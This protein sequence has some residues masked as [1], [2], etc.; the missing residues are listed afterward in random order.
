[1]L[2]IYFQERFIIVF[3][4]FGIL[5]ISYIN[6]LSA[7]KVVSFNKSNAQKITQTR[8]D[9]KLLPEQKLSTAKSSR[10]VNQYSFKG[11]YLFDSKYG[12]RDF[13]V[14]SIP[15][16]S[17]VSDPGEPALPVNIDKILVPG[18]AKVNI[19]IVESQSVLLKD[20]YIQP[21]LT[22]A[23][24]T[25]GDDDRKFVIDSRVYNSNSFYPAK[26]VYQKSGQLLR[27]NKIVSIAIAPVQFNPVKK[28]LRVYTKIKYK[29]TY[30]SRKTFQDLRKENS[31][32]YL[33]MMRNI[34]LNA[35]QIPENPK[36]TST[37]SKASAN[38]DYIILTHDNYHA[39]ADK[40][41]K[42]KK[43][44]GYSTEVLSS[45][46]WTATKVKD[47][48][49][50]RYANYSPKPDYFVIIGDQ[51][52][53]PAEIHQAPDGTNFGTDLYY[54][55]MDGSTD[56]VPD[57]AHGRISVSSSTEALN[58][59][60]KIVNY[61]R[62]PV[63]DSSFYNKG[64]NCAYFQGYNYNGQTYCERRFLHTSE[65]IRSYLMNQGYNIERIYETDATL[66]P[67][68]YQNGYYS[69]GQAIPSG[70][71][72]SNGFQWDGSTQ[73]ITSSINNGR[74]F[75]FHRDH[76]YTNG[77]GWAHPKF[78][79]HPNDQHVQNLSNGNKLPVVFSIDCHTGDFTQTEAFAE[80]FL[81]HSNGGAVGVVAP[82]YYSYSGPNDGFAAGL[83]DAVW[84]SPGLIPDFGAGGISNPS[85]S[86]HGDIRTM[87]NVVNQALI[88]MEETWNGYGSRI[89]YS[90]EVYHYF[91]DP[92]M[93]IFTAKPSAITA[94]INDTVKDFSIE[95]KNASDNDALATAYYNGKLL[96]KTN[97]SNGSGT[98]NYQDSIEGMVTVT[99]SGVNKKPLV[100]KLYVD[101]VVKSYP[102]GKQA[103]NISVDSSSSKSVSL[104]ITWDEGTGDHRIA[105]INNQDNFTDPVDGQEYT[106]DN[107][108][109]HN[110][111]QVVY[112]GEGN[113]VTVYNL[114]EN[115]VY[116][117]RVYEYNN[118]DTSTLY[119]TT[120]E[121]GNPSNQLDDSTYPVEL[122]SFDGEQKGESIKLSWKTASE[123]SNNHFI[124]ERI[125]GEHSKTI[126]KIEGSGTSNTIRN[127][128]FTHADPY[129]GI[130]YYR[131]IQV[132]HDG[133]REKYETIAVDYQ[134]QGT[135][136]IENLHREGDELV[137]QLKG[138]PDGDLELG[139]YTVDGRLIKQRPV[140]SDV[141][142]MDKP[143][144]LNI[145][146]CNQGYY[147]FKILANNQSI[148]RKIA[149]LK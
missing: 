7:Q 114:N 90:H 89:K 66:N 122:I 93:R 5:I 76:G 126:A 21:A 73:D 134:N 120:E 81:R 136:S 95:V 36:I 49:H 82:S 96:S 27:G 16:F 117:F 111:E 135:L 9:S 54:A 74:F 105:K 108:Y 106:A 129:A 71:L 46:S 59:V 86:P 31:K 123:V 138:S 64:T 52:D 77:W 79:N 87:G 25:E 28:R 23:K 26:P 140:H 20:F 15:E 121:T 99:L 91:G 112:V 3:V 34:S 132:D 4:M 137:F 97:L 44:L 70:L 32:Q 62:N 102:P 69:D 84:S 103:S 11:A 12:K 13:D 67:T 58:V 18:N 40:L 50:T 113:Q 110:G 131:L 17:S 51:Q 22:P 37:R 1:M 14:L 109:H 10:I 100:K 65:E 85:L 56:Y 80:T 41:A 130:N 124:L 30:Q 94:G 60:N 61:E 42:W 75:V 125:T 145:P 142:Y 128:S 139:L 33:K 39:A 8:N 48:I 146:G 118:E 38:K 148:S 88:R 83:F 53:V 43:M 107:Y 57:M 143:L 133:K 45:S 115:D 141:N 68:H 149:I 29:V 78:A 116:W 47:S 55:C 63:S 101:N 98:M 35:S 6:Q 24:D 147:V 144:K 104:T 92:A 2:K 19:E 72:R 119:T 127:Y